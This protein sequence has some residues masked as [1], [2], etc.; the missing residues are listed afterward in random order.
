MTSPNTKNAPESYIGSF[1]SLI[2]KYEIRYEGVLYHLNVSDSTIGLKNVKSFG[3]EGRKKDG[4][5]VL[6]SEKVYEYI[7]FR[8]S[9]IKDLEVKSSPPPQKEEQIYQDPAIIQ[10]QY[11]GI[12]TNSPLLSSVAGK[13]L[14]ESSSWQDTPTLTSKASAGSLLSHQPGT[15]VSQF[16]H[17]QA[18]QNAASPS[19]PLPIYWQGYNGPSN[20]ISPT[21]FQSSS[22]VSSPLTGPNRIWTSETDCSPALGS[23]TASE[24]AAHQS[25]SIAPSHL[26]PNFSSC[27]IPVQCSPAPLTPFPASFKGPLSSTAAYM[28]DNNPNTSSV[29]SSCPDTKATEA[30]ISGRVVPGPA[31]SAQTMNYPA[32][33][34]LGSASG[35][36]LSPPPSLLTPGQLVTS[37]P[38]VLSSTQAMYPDKK[39]MA[40]MLPS[41]FNSPAAISPP[42]TQLPLLPLPTPNLQFKKDEVWGYLGKAKQSGKPETIEDNTADQNSR[43]KE[44]DGLVKNGDPEPAY[45]KDDFFDT[46]SCNS[47][48]RGTREG[49][50]RFSERMRLDT[51][52]F[53]N[54]Q[55]RANQGYGGYVAG[56][57]A[58]YRGRYGEGRRYGYGGRGHGGNMHM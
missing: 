18:A 20:N 2:S 58:N 52:T 22:T 42:V 12:S 19:F 33:S 40:A 5:Q 13:T 54:F 45:R 36:L 46:I 41:S 38:P 16:N 15:Q 50:N 57:G 3:T 14:T 24:S 55:Q 8:G 27:P 31:H 25:P 1:I 23:V 4:P 39:D 48:N 6:P 37:R 47:L 26:N 10:S 9:D 7:L 28:T 53:G 34:F 49:Q 21:P 17:P 43:G 35:P 11:A 29:P 51:E 30:Q 44:A 32:S 56:R